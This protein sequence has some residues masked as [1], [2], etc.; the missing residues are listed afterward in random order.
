MRESFLRKRV[1]GERLRDARLR[2]VHC[3]RNLIFALER[4]S[5][6]AREREARRLCLRDLNLPEVDGLLG[7]EGE[8]SACKVVGEWHGSFVEG[9]NDAER[10]VLASVASASAATSA[11]VCVRR[12]GRSG[13]VRVAE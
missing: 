11:G 9:R 2:S 8:R 1:G 7:G 3:R 4:K 10:N 5:V 12:G 13:G 6:M